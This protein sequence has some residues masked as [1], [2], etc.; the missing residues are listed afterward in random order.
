M[1]SDMI[2]DYYPEECP[3]CFKDL[4]D[5]VCDYEQIFDD[6]MDQDQQ[7]LRESRRRYD[8]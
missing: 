2:D 7:E 3:C 4:V 1:R 6:E 5:C 8:G